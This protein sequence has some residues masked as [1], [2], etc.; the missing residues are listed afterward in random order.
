MDK[1]AQKFMNRLEKV[2]QSESN[3]DKLLS[4]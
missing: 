2:L 3:A 4:S 1:Q